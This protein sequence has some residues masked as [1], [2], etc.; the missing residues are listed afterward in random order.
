LVPDTVPTQDKGHQSVIT[1]AIAN[2]KGGVGKTTAAIDLSTALVAVGERVLVI[3]FDPQ[4]DAL[5][6]LGIEPSRR[7]K[8][9]YDVMTGQIGLAEA[10]LPTAVPGLDVVPASNDLIGLEA[11]LMQES[12]RPFRLREAVSGLREHCQGLPASEGYSYLL[13]DCPPSV[14]IL[15]LNALTAAD[16]VLVPVQR[17]FFAPEGTSQF[18]NTIDQIREN[19]NPGLELLL[20][21]DECNTS[22][23]CIRLATEFVEREWQRRSVGGGDFRM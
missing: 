9:S 4:G 11:D 2:P 17:E 16:A 7:G 12:D 15:T 22:Q 18:K 10:A 8:T 1:I 21:D 20:F 19:L 14:N 23:A 6:G 5:T 3:D 13:I